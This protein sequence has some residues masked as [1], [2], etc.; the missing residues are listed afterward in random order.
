MEIVDGSG[1]S[2]AEEQFAQGLVPGGWGTNDVDNFIGRQEILRL[3][4]NMG[5]GA[6]RDRDNVKGNMQ[7]KL[8][9]SILDAELRR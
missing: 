2:G 8:D 6:D 1:P 4:G 5:M 3:R 9:D 7:A